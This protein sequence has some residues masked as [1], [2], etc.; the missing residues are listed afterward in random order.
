MT[1]RKLKRYLHIK[2]AFDRIFSLIALIV[3]SPLILILALLIF[4]D[5]PHGSPFYTQ[6]RVG[7]D[8]VPFRMY[9][10]R[11]M[12][13]GAEEELERL[14]EFNEMSGPPFKI[15]GDERI[16]R[17]GRVLRETGLD[18]ILQFLNVLKGDMSVV[19]PR[20]PLP[21]EVEQYTEHQM[22]RLSVLPGI[23]CYW[24]IHEER[25]QMPFDEWVALDLEYIA[26]R[27]VSTDLRIMFSTIGAMARRQG[28]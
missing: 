10:L 16:T 5:D 11:T 23:T 27:S 20:P 3:L 28:H 19:G 14:M 4:L 21:K 25:N 8:G 18:E 2:G 12:R 9:K 6:N 26:R 1:N 24:Q 13:K 17:V 15:K 7:K 22:K